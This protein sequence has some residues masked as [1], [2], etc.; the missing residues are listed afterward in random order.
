M[1]E[2]MVGAKLWTLIS[3]QLPSAGDGRVTDNLQVTP[4]LGFSWEAL[5]RSV[6]EKFGLKLKFRF[7]YEL[8]KKIQILCDE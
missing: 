3:Q 1:A 6:E 4:R 5:A 2:W 8:N 7:R